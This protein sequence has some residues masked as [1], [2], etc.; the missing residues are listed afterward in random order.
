MNPTD[1]DKFDT[2]QEDLFNSLLLIAENSGNVSAEAAIDEAFKYN[3]EVVIGNLQFDFEVIKPLMLRQ[4]KAKW[5]KA[6]DE[7]TVSCKFCNAETSAG[8]AHLHQEAYVC[9]NCFD[10]R[11]RTTQ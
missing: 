8:T 2:D 10:E 5:D 6:V 9:E 7:Q 3:L 1:Q 4:L 11:L